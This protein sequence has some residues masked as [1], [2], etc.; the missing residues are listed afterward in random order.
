MSF[1]AHDRSVKAMTFIGRQLV[2]GSIDGDLKVYQL[3]D[4]FASSE[5]VKYQ[6]P[7]IDYTPT[8]KNMGVESIL[9][10]SPLEKEF[11]VIDN[12]S[13]QKCNIPKAWFQ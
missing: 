1:Q 12:F 13:I 5:S 2:T 8:M 10:I 11:Y 7:Y 9:Q 4:L 3:S 6:P